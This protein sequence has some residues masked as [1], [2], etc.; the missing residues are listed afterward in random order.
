MIELAMNW[1]GNGVFQKEISKRQEI[2][3]KYLD[4][5]IAGLKASG[6]IQNVDG[7]KSGYRLVKNPENINVY[8][9]YKAFESKLLVIDCL[10][11]KG[12]CNRDRTCASRNFWYGLNIHII[13]YL[14]STN[15]KELADKQKELNNMGY[16]D[17]YYI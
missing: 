4:Q 15:L 8:D 10:S 12:I 9:I 7:R 11:E 17:M 16:V 1:N 14:E 6:L 13:D 5:I 2:S 3:I